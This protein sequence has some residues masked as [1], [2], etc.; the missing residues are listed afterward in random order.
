LGGP[1]TADAVLHYRRQDD[2]RRRL[3]A[4]ELTALNPRDAAIA[5]V[6]VL[7]DEP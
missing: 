2:V 6:L 1:F 3:A 4:D 7:D 5:D